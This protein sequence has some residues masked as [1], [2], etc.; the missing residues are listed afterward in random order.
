MATIRY[1]AGSME[2]T[3]RGTADGF[4]VVV[5]RGEAGKPRSVDLLLLGL[6]SCTISTVNHYVRRK[7]L[8]IDQVAVEVSAVL[9]EKEN[10][11]ENFRVTLELGEA[12]SETYRKTLANVAKTCRIH[13]TIISNPRIDIAVRS[14]TPVIAD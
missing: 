2:S 7:N 8:P 3:F 11:Y 4:E 5:D 14:Q 12:F 13:K 10:C 6:G 1:E 9:N